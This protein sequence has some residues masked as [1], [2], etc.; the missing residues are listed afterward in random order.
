MTALH[1]VVGLLVLGWGI[2]TVMCMVVWERNYR[3]YRRYIR[4]LLN[5]YTSPWWVI[6]ARLDREIGRSVRHV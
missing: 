5:D 4:K 6:R 2:N 3:R 1:V